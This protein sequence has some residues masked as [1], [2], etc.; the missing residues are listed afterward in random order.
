MKLA[1]TVVALVPALGVAVSVTAQQPAAATP[2]L[3]KRLGGYDAMAAVTDDFLRPLTSD[4]SFA[5]FFSGHSAD[6]LKKIRQ[7]V[8]R[9]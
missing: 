2:T 7:L 3:Y 8:E 1:A 5:R 6:S 4:A 9:P